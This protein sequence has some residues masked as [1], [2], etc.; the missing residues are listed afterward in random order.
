MNQYTCRSTLATLVAVTCLM[1]R[2]LEAQVTLRSASAVELRAELLDAG[3]R[4]LPGNHFI[5]GEKML[6]RVRITHTAALDW[7]DRAARRQSQATRTDRG[8]EARTLEPRPE[9]IPIGLPGAPWHGTLDVSTVLARARTNTRR[10]LSVEPRLLE[11]TAEVAWAIDSRKLPPG[12]SVHALAFPFVSPIDG[13]GK[14]VRAQVEVILVDE[15]N[16]SR[17]QLARV[18]Q[19]RAQEALDTRR[20]A[21]AIRAAETALALGP[22]EPFDRAVLH[23]IAGQ[24]H[25]AKG[26][27]SAA[28]ASFEKARAVLRRDLPWRTR[29]EE[30]VQ[31]RLA[32]LRR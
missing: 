16:A 28:V 19:H 9:P 32:R 2:S 26:A 17:V 31:Q 14:I 22:G 11:T 10:D 23:A 15:A 1:D 12:R 7:M 25:E 18:A 20:H 27:R 6:L 29:L 4:R 24:A 30:V 3:R 8:T 5:H 21:E 13:R